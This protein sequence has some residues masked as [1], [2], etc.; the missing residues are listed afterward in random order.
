MRRSNLLWMTPLML[1]VAGCQTAG[2]RQHKQ[3]AQRN[4]NN[5]RAKII[6]RLAEQHFEAGRFDEAIVAA[7]QALALEAGQTPPYKILAG[8]NLELSKPATAMQAIQ[9]A[10]KLGLQSPRL[11]YL[12][13]VILEQRGDVEQALTKYEEALQL[14]PGQIDFLTAE[15]E[16]LVS[17]HRASEALTLID[18]NADRFD[19]SATVAALGGHVAALLGDT[20]GAIS[21]YRRALGA[22]PESAT[23]R[24]AL[25]LVLADN[26]RCTEALNV[27]TPMLEPAGPGNGSGGTT[28]GAAGDEL[29]AVRRAVARCQLELGN[30]GA[31]RD[32]LIDYAA[33]NRDDLVAQ[34]ILAKA[35][36]STGDLFTAAAA[37]Q[38]AWRGRPDD[39]EVLLL[40]SAVQWQQGRLDEARAT[41]D[42]LLARAPTDHDALRLL[43][44]V[45]RDAA[46]AVP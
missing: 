1:V 6:C 21:R 28:G 19:D 18:R 37:T 22:A 39:V 34:V 20:E 2:P 33:R 3:R 17:L 35:A 9:A 4:W 41:L 32:L 13:G 40:R 46:D 44:A 24:R 30:A 11:I 7:G 5:V 27:L 16:C 14:E 15:V 12:T 42:Q 26:K 8:A 43:A 23:V 31:A 25:G 38:T 45:K 36:L 29:P 10:E